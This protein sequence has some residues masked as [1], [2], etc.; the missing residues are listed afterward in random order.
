MLS[1][2]NIEQTPKKRGRPRKNQSADYVENGAGHSGK[3]SSDASQVNFDTMG[4]GKIIEV[5]ENM[6]MEEFLISS[7]LG[8][9]LLPEAVKTVLSQENDKKPLE[10]IEEI[11]FFKGNDRLTIRFSKKHNRMFRIQIFLNNEI[12]VR[13]VTYT[14]ARTGYSF[15]NLL[16]GAMQK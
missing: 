7:G 5:P 3:H 12:E 11:D 6:S 16:K 15:W 13:P 9:K 2:E 8:I 14:G 10:T 1:E 4:A